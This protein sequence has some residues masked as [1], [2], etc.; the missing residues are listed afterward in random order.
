MKTTAKL[1]LTAL[2]LFAQFIFAQELALVR[3]N[4]KFGYLNT[5]GSWAIQ[6]TYKSAKNFSNGLAAVYNGLL[7]G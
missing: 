1:I 7:W 6:P 3:E 4:D 2:T 5:D